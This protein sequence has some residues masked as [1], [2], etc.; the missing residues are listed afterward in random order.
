M[1]VS[2]PPQRRGMIVAKQCTCIAE[3]LCRI[4]LA[5]WCA[6][7][8][9][10]QRFNG[11]KWVKFKQCFVC[12][13]A[14]RRDFSCKYSSAVFQGVNYNWIWRVR[15]SRV[16]VTQSHA[17][18]RR[19]RRRRRSKRP[20]YDPSAPE[21]SKFQCT[22]FAG[23]CECVRTAKRIKIIQTYYALLCHTFV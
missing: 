12:R 17:W 13:T 15:N 19:R 14:W 23:L 20:N 16:C 10:R 4:V 8:R 21:F 6:R 2:D 7:W 3:C 1:R 9:Q 18:R 22:S 5:V 11:H